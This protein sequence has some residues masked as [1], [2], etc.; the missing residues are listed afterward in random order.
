MSGSS[1]AM[2]DTADQGGRGGD[3]ADASGRR[4]AVRK[5]T[6]HRPFPAGQP[7]RESATSAG[8]PGVRPFIGLRRKVTN[9]G[10][11]KGEG[12]RCALSLRLLGAVIRRPTKLRES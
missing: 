6:A 7:G 3:R 4:A 12:E 10:L 2:A 5:L 8:L 1:A 11:T 9:A